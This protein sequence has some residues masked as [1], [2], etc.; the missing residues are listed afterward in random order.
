VDLT[1]CLIVIRILSLLFGLSTSEIVSVVVSEI[2]VS[3]AIGCES[4]VAGI[5][6]GI[7][8]SVLVDMVYLF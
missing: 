7:M 3:N 6:V 8:S 2:E 4:V 5:L 1:C